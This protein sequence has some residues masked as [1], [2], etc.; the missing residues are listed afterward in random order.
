M[1]HS[2]ENVVISGYSAIT[3]AGTGVAAVTD[4]AAAGRD[5]FTILPEDV[6]QG[7][8]YRW[9]KASAFKVSEYMSPMKARKMDRC[10]Q[11]AVAVTGLALKDAGLDLKTLS[12]DRMGIALGSGFCGVSTSAEFLG[13]Y[14]A[15]GVDGLIPMIFPNT[16]PNSPASNASIEYG[17]K[18]PNVTLIQRFCSAE[19]AFLMAC[20]FIEEGRADVVL[21]GGA[22]EVTPLMLQGLHEMGR[23]EPNTPPF[24]EGCGII[25]L[26]SAS[27]AANRGACIRGRVDQI[28]TIGLLPTDRECEAMELLLGGCGAVSLLTLSGTCLDHA[29]IMAAL[30][31][32]DRRL[33]VGPCIGRSLG[34][35]GVSIAATAASLHADET[36]LHLSASPEGPFFSI[37]LSGGAPV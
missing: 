32:A 13:G 14:F 19:S 33:E 28:R 16:V 6:L 21:A 37:C 18:G 11:Y 25:V 3:A 17:F 36:A 29:A 34:M 35:G 27:H 4:L 1:I 23:F 2:F 26:E 9:G 22:D 30:P 10:S 8:C 20:R 24:G 5:A 15:D 12:L 7:G 31:V